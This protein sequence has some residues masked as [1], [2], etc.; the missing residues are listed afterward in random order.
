MHVVIRRLTALSLTAL[1]LALASAFVLPAS[2]AAAQNSPPNDSSNDSPQS[3]RV[4]RWLVV[5]CGL[6]GDQQH[7][8]R[9]TGAVKKIAAAAEPVLL[10][11]TDHLRVLVG[12]DE[13]LEDINGSISDAGVCTADSVQNLFQTLSQ[14]MEAKAECWIIFLGHAQLFGARSTFNVQGADFDAGDFSRSVNALGDHQRV[15]WLTMPVSGLWVKPLKAERSVCIAATEAS[16]EF[17]GTEMPYA[18]ADVLAGTQSHQALADVDEDRQFTLLDLY[19]SVSLEVHHRY[20]A[21]ARLQTEHAQLDDNGDGTGKELQEAYLPQE[22]DEALTFKSQPPRR[23][24]LTSNGDGDLAR[25][26]LIGKP[27]DREDEPVEQP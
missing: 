25:R 27:A 18:L 1:T 22:E 24:Q 11:P 7:R 5:L 15:L 12:D 3:P 19:L 20:K 9:L 8:E 4:E 26:M 21:L 6:P 23:I 2:S 16:P 10:V 14:K 13:M 17:T